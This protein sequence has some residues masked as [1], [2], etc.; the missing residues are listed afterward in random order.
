MGKFLRIL[1][2]AISH[3]YVLTGIGILFLLLHDQVAFH[4][5]EFKVEALQAQALLI[6]AQELHG[7]TT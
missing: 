4:Q 3:L 1:F 6:I 2:L 5:A 7:S